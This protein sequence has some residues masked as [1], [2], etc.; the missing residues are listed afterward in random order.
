MTTMAPRAY[1]V[2]ER[3]QET[4]DTATLTLEPVGQPMATPLPGPDSICVRHWSVAGS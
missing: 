3:R 2:I 1:R 4:A